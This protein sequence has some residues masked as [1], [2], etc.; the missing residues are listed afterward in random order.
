MSRPWKPYV[1][2]R[3][4]L[5]GSC[6]KNERRK[7]RKI[8]IKKERKREREREREGRTRVREGSEYKWFVPHRAFLSSSSLRV[9]LKSRASTRTLQL[10]H[11]S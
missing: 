9:S 7:E 6:E 4:N 5:S 2:D 10:L 8:G 1:A 11:G 3:G